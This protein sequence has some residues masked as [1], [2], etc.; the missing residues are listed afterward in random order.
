MES[1]L[2]EACGGIADEAGTPRSGI[3][4]QRSESSGTPDDEIILPRGNP[5]FQSP[6]KWTR[7]KNGFDIAQWLEWA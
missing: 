7:H 2:E 1:A 3:E 5:K 4:N 6:N